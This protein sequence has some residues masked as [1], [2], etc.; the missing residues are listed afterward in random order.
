MYDTILFVSATQ[1]A[2]PEGFL[3][4]NTHFSTKLNGI[5]DQAYA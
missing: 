1:E 5:L 3:L 4:A 2:T